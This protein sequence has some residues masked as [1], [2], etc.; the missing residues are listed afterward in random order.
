MNL[1]IIFYQEIR[2]HNLRIENLI[3]Y[4]DKSKERRN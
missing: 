4:K 2:R 1:S 3:R